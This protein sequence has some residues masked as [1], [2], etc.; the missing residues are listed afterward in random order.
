MRS[1]DG[2][3][4]RYA[5]RWALVLSVLNLQIVLKVSQSYTCSD[6]RFYLLYIFHK[7][8]YL[9]GCIASI[10]TV[11]YPVTLMIP[12]YCF[13]VEQQPIVSGTEDLKRVSLF[14]G[15]TG[16][17]CGIFHSYMEVMS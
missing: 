2:C 13:G 10:L 3:L 17:R 12:V 8:V 5:A 11:H 6:S 14:L 4:A 9:L 7:I 16:R 15:L 1:G